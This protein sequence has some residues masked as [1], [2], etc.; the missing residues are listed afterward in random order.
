MTKFEQL[1][2]FPLAEDTDD[3]NTS[4]MYGITPERYAELCGVFLNSLK[5]KPI[6]ITG[7]SSMTNQALEGCNNR[8]EALAMLRIVNADS[9]FLLRLANISRIKQS[10]NN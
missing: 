4:H 10:V 7:L 5:N 1:F 8:R 3:I 9:D 6:S 2:G